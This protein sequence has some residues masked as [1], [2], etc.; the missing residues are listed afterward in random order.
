MALKNTP[1][2]IRFIEPQSRTNNQPL[3]PGLHVG[4]LLEEEEEEEEVGM[5]Q[6]PPL[7]GCSGDH[8]EDSEPLIEFTKV[9]DKMLVVS[10]AKVSMKTQSSKTLKVS[11]DMGQ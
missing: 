2:S 5:N 11:G 6:A 4:G 10:C 3:L 9:E 1:L 8:Y 7:G